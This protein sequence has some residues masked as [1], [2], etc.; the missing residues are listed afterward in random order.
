MVHII[1]AID[2]IHMPNICAAMTLLSVKKQVFV[3][4]VVKKDLH[5]VVLLYF[6]LFLLII[7]ELWVK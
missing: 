6:F 2:E 7:E 5:T 4:A 1:I 3:D